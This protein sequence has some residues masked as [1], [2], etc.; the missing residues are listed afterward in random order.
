MTE[1]QLQPLPNPPNPS[2]CPAPGRSSLPPSLPPNPRA[3][4][5]PCEVWRRGQRR[6]ARATVERSGDEAARRSRSGQR[7]RGA[8][9]A[10][11]P[12]GIAVKRG[13]DPVRRR[14]G[15]GSA[16]S[17]RLRPPTPFYRRC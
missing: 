14:K 9:G 13:H 1:A 2:P 17:S 16:A 3:A 15:A 6:P 12:C 4:P 7:W 10:A 8:G 5:G 11:A